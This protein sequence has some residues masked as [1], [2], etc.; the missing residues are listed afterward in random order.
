MKFNSSRCNWLH[1]GQPHRFGEYMID[2]TTITSCN[3]VKGLG[4]QIDSQLEFHDHT[5][6]ITK[7]ANHLLASIQKTFQHFNKNT[8]INLNKSYIQPV[9]KLC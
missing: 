4:V 1:L 5:T 7:K 2:G 9:L 3:V 6:T 8:I